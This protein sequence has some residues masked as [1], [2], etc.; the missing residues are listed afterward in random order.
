MKATLEFQLPEEEYEYTA[1]VKGT[2]SLCV[3]D[4]LLRE[5]RNAIKY[6]TGPLCETLEVDE[7]VNMITLEKIRDYI[8]ELR[9]SYG[10]P[11]NE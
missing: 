10:V 3:L 2:S 7:A 4:E 5:L 6:N 1:A 8:W 11:N 9:D